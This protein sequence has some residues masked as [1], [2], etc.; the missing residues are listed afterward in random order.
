MAKRVTA[1]NSKEILAVEQMAEDIQTAEELYADGMPYELERIENEIRFY[2][3]QAGAALL[4]MGKRFIRIKAHEGH[5]KFLEALGRLGLAERSARYA[6]AA[7]RRFS[8]RPAVADLGVSKMKALTVLDDDEIDALGKGDSVRGMNLDDIDR[9]STRELRENLRKEK[10]QAKKEKETR[11]KER[12]SF[13]QSML[14]KDAKINELDMRLSGQEPPTKEQIAG[15][16]LVKMTPDYSIAIAKVNGAVREAYALVV[17]A[18]KIEG[19]DAQRLSEWLNQ[20]SPDMQTFHDLTGT[21]TD[22]ID[23][24][25]P[26]KDWRISDLPGMV[27]PA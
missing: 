18:E 24:A 7:A 3:D 23:N 19:V 27:E 20:F 1:K 21:W 12:T 10:E 16:T 14:Q 2:Q 22:E 8:N 11:K 5:G 25:G 26:V 15:D 9:M 6:M 17:K 13:D 4:E